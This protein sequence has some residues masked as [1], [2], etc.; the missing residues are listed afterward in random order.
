MLT[1]TFR[2]RGAG[3]TD[4]KVGLFGDEVMLPSNLNQSK[5]NFSLKGLTGELERAS[6]MMISP[7]RSVNRA[8]LN[9]DSTKGML[10]SLE[11]RTA[12]LNISSC[13]SLFK[14]A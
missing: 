10:F 4:E 5:L 13:F 11:W 9:N 12:V 7:S 2:G 14:S 3:E 1:L 6:A 8:G